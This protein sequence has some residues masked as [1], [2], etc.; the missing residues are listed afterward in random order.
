MP[1]PALATKPWLKPA[2][3][4][5]ALLG[6]GLVLGDLLHGGASSL[7]LLAAASAG[8]WWIGGRRQQPEDR[9][10]Q[11]PQAL[12]AHCRGLLDQF[13]DLELPCERQ[14]RQLGQLE[15]LGE[16]PDRHV[17]LA[18]AS[19]LELVELLKRKLPTSAPLQLHLAKTLPLAPERWA[20]PEELLR[21]DLVIYALAAAPSAADL[22]WLEA[23]PL[24]LPLL[25]LGPAEG[26]AEQVAAW[27]A[28]L[29]ARFQLWQRDEALPIT[30]PSLARQRQQ[31]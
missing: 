26:S 7:G 6:G 19:E 24:E 5:S 1:I 16:R 10:P 23:A 21:A 30:L 13:V 18:G 8:L 4:G 12:L 14:Q 25:V 29:G 28:Q 3:V 9:L 15:Q 27:S 17:V 11:S 20:W 22:R 31:T 2:L